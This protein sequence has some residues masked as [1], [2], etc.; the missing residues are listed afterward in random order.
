MGNL[1]PPF[2]NVGCHTHSVEGRDSARISSNDNFLS[3]EGKTNNHIA[4]FKTGLVT[5]VT[6]R[7]RTKSKKQRVRPGTG[8]LSF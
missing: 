3:Q 7:Q 2:G 8:R 1:W 6:L 4:S 5:D